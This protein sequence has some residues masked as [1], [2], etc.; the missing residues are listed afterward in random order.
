MLSRNGQRIAHLSSEAPVS[1][2]LLHRHD[3]SSIGVYRALDFLKMTPRRVTQN[4]V[5]RPVRPHERL[6]F[7]APDDACIL[8]L[9]RVT[10]TQSGKR[11]ETATHRYLAE[12]FSV[13][14]TLLQ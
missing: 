14:S 13:R 9:T 4:I 11:I 2:E 5:A 8:E 10:T 12:H 3:V 1:A 7:D 6:E